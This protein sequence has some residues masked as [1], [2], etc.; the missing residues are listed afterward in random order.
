MIFCRFQYS[1]YI[2][3]WSH[4]RCR[5]QI[6]TFYL[7]YLIRDEIHIRKYY[8]ILWLK[9][10][11]QRN[12]FALMAMSM[13]IQVFSVL[14]LSQN[15]E[16]KL[17]LSFHSNRAFDE[18]ILFKFCIQDHCRRQCN[19]PIFSGTCVIM[20]KVCMRKVVPLLGSCK[21]SV[22][23][24]HFNTFRQFYISAQRKQAECVM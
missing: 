13:H 21:C 19:I 9:W 15:P 6:R 4:V 10:S 14:S 12:Y 7:S 11:I 8:L 3:L 2:K 22:V 20:S 16:V 23:F 24:S 18:L 17:L 1:V 5:C